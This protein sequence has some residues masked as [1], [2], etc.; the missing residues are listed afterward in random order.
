[1][2]KLRFRVLDKKDRIV[3]EGTN[4]EVKER[5]DISKSSNIV[6]YANYGMFLKGKYR[7]E[8]IGEKDPK[9]DA[10]LEMQIKILEREKS[11]VGYR[12]DIQKNIRDL[13]KHGIKVKAREVIER[14]A[15]RRK[16]KYYILEKEES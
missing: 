13:K 14:G 5:F 1:M 4:E 9:Y 16:D 3:F 10:L 6:Q 8:K 15:K 2:P 11:V 12:K 7:V